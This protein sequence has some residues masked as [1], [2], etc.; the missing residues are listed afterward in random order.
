MSV[1]QRKNQSPDRNSTH[2]LLNIV[3]VLYPLSY[4]NSWR[5]RSFYLSSRVTGILHTARFSTAK[6]IVSR[7][8][9]IMMVNSELGNEM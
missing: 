1:G 4:K 7:D 8:K 5:A 6:V 9:L 3:L 2:D